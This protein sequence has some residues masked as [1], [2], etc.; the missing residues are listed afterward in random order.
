MQYRHQR[1]ST[2][3]RGHDGEGG[4]VEMSRTP[5]D[6]IC[7]ME[8]PSAIYNDGPSTYSEIGGFGTPNVLHRTAGET[9]KWSALYIMYDVIK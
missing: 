5:E 9:N 6:S 1:C 3:P 2:R 8:G 7:S 4:E